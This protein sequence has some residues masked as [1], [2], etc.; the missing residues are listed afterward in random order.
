MTGAQSGRI[1]TLDLIRGVA[2]LGILA[3]NIGG[4]AGP[5]LSTLSPELPS[6]VSRADET[7]YALSFL[8]FEGKMRALF[9]LLFGASTVLLIDRAEESGRF[10]IGVQVR[11]L[12]WLALFGLAHFYLLWWGDIL[13]AYAIAGFVALTLVEL[14]PRTLVI[15]ALA[16]FTIW[17]GSG[18]LLSAPDVLRENRV[19]HGTATPAETRAYGELRQQIEDYARQETAALSG[20]FADQARS[21]IVGKTFEPFTGAWDALGETLPLMMIGMALLRTGF[22]SGAWRKRTLVAI[23]LGA[24]VTGLALSGAI[25]AFVWPRAFPFEAM[26]S[27]IRYWTAIPHLVTAIGYAC[28]LV[29]IAPRLSGTLPGHWL[30]NCGRMAFSNYIGTTV[31]MTWIFYGWGLGWI[32]RFGPA[33]QWAFVLLGWAAMILFSNLWL[34]RFRRGPLEWLWRSLVEGHRLPNLR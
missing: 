14:K 12:A 18:A 6:A 17:H 29:L 33:W 21:R 2:V 24:S 23:G 4:F 15:A 3:I 31:L 19:L 30:M 11:R 10:G 27:A 16:I 20:S 28:L 1:V 9:T 34:G 32:E 5:S 22:F 13:F 26:E 25:I 7:A 8:L